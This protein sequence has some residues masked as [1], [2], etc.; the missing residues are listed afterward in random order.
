MYPPAK[1]WVSREQVFE[2]I[3][4]HLRKHYMV[5]HLFPDEPDLLARTLDLID[6]GIRE[7]VDEA[8]D[9][10]YRVL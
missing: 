1:M 9:D 2:E 10:C 4:S 5:T 8:V 3:R 6:E 7:A